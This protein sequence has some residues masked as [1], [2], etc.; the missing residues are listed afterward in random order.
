[1]DTVHQTKEII[2][3]W[4]GN[5]RNGM[6]AGGIKWKGM[7]NEMEWHE[8]DQNGMVCLVHVIQIAS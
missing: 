2:M 8:T 4:N 3:E 5:V 1:M 7:W 6:S